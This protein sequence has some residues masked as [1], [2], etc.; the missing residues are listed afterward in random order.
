MEQEEWV[1]EQKEYVKMAG[2]E[3][4]TGVDEGNW[5]SSGLSRE[6]NE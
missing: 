3:G 6:E 4:E 2:V 1:R 5:G